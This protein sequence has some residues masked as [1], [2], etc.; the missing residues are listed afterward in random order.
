MDS[1]GRVFYVDH[2]TRTTHWELPSAA[3]DE[4]GAAA[5]LLAGTSAD[6]D[7][8]PEP[9]QPAEP[10]PA[11]D[12]ALGSMS[13]GTTAMFENPMRASAKRAKAKKEAAAARDLVKKNKQARDDA[14]R[15]AKQDAQ[16]V[17]DGIYRAKYVPADSA[18]Y[19]MQSKY[20]RSTIS[21]T[22]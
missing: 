17:H 15:A 1:T 19:L 9:R 5:A 18:D 7:V 14:L 6:S 13:A 11:R 20:G 4:V 3:H 21:V 2:A 8:L 10:A 22:V 16:A 12:R